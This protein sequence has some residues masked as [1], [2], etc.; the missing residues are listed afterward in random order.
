MRCFRVGDLG[1]AQKETL[2]TIKA[3]VSP[4]VTKVFQRVEIIPLNFLDYTNSQGSAMTLEIK[5]IIIL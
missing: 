1:F 4:M 5:N 2:P 3:E